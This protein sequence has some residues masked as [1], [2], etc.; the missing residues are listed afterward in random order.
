MIDIVI[1]GANGK[2]GQ[3]VAQLINVQKDMRVIA[4]LDIEYK[5]GNFTIYNDLSQIPE[6]QM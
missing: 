5:D 4:G 6:T 3:A 2:M 1:S